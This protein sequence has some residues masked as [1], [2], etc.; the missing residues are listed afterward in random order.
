MKDH[1]FIELL[2]P[3]L[4]G[5]DYVPYGLRVHPASRPLWGRVANTLLAGLADSLDSRGL[6]FL[7]AC[8]SHGTIVRLRMREKSIEE[9]LEVPQQ[10][11]DK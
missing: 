11:Q 1:D 7:V 8:E 10:H 2:Q 6:W 5:H 9:I 3:V 4:D